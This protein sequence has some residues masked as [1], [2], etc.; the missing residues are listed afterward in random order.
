MK[1]FH[2][3]SWSAQARGFADSIYKSGIW[4]VAISEWTEEQR[5]HELIEHL[6]NSYRPKI[7][8]YR[9]AKRLYRKYKKEGK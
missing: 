1:T 5:K 6:Q 3:R 8:V 7:V 9:A 4:M 2:P